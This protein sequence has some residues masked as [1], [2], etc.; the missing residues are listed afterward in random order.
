[1]TGGMAAAIGGYS[2]RRIL[3]NIRAYQNKSEEQ[4]DKIINNYKSK[5]GFY[6]FFGCYSLEQL[7]Y[8]AAKAVKHMR[9]LE[10]E[11]FPMREYMNVSLSG[12]LLKL[13]M[14]AEQKIK[15][16]NLENK[17]YKEKK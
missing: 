17:I 14:R 11:K 5:N 2:R 4:L 7:D 12:F 13:E 3:D 15:N 1:M 8:R 16:D 10:W 6:R 9:V